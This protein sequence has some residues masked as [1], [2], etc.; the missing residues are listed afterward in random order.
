MEYL[1]VLLFISVDFIIL[2]LKNEPPTNIEYTH[3]QYRIIIF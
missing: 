2:Y 1:N 3:R